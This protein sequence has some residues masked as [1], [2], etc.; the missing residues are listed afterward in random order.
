MSEAITLQE[1]D[2]WEVLLN[3]DQ[4]NLGK[5]LLVLKADKASLAELTE[6]EWQEFGAIVKALEKAIAREFSPTHFNWQCLMNNAYELDSS[7]EPHVHWHVTPRYEQ[8]VEVG[9]E[10]F[11]DE[12]YPRTNK[13]PKFI[14]GALLRQIANK[15]IPH[16]DTE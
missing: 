9:E 4:Q 8:P 2:C 16:L 7:E 5:S 14:D 6:R 1:T 11:I 15:I 13:Q 12:N 10:E 3:P